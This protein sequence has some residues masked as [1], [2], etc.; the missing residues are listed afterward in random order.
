MLS[1]KRDNSLGHLRGLLQDGKVSCVR[2]FNHA[3]PVSKPVSQVAPVARCNPIV[4]TLDHQYRGPTGSS[5]T[6]R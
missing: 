6:P 3:D 2:Q 5:T 1:Q 4:E